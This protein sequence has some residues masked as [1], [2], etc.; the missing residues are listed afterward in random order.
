MFFIRR[1]NKLFIRPTIFVVILLFILSF[2]T[3]SFS[4][5][6][7]QKKKSLQFN[8]Q[9]VT[10]IQNNLNSLARKYQLTHDKL[11]NTEY[12]IG[13]TKKK[14]STLQA[15]IATRQQIYS[16]RMN[17]MYKY[18]KVG[19]LEIFFGSTNFYDLVNR[20]SLLQKILE[21]DVKLVNEIKAAKSVLE[22]EQAAL[23]F[24]KKKYVNLVTK[25]KREKNNLVGNLESQQNLLAKLQKEVKSEEQRLQIRAL[26][27]KLFASRG[28]RSSRYS[29]FS[30]RP[31]G[32]FN[33]PVAG[34]HGFSNDWG[35]PRSGGR[36]HKGT[37]IF[38]RNGTP[39]VAVVS[40]TVTRRSGGLGGLAIW[41]R[42]RDGN[43]YYYAHL[44]GFAG[45]GGVS[46][47]QVIGY[48]G[49]TGNARGGAPHLHF[50]IHPGG[51]RAVNP[52]PIL[53]NAD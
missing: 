31:S 4:T 40:G 35:N 30:F 41:L 15:K 51:G 42:G 27:T 33:F 2:S 24:Q 18:G 46:Q 32:G 9:K 45:S 20:L 1:V 36:R 22:K 10:Q 12:A 14:I 37:D 28:S 7:S 13:L 26:Q 5:S 23:T 44:S 52:Y 6:L 29:S 43:T 53:R 8:R 50:E 25:L 38:A 19:Y 17:K 48:V 21:S 34:A 49:A 11:E 3:P 16:V 39:V 47:G